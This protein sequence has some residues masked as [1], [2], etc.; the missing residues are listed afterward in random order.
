[1]SDPLWPEQVSEIRFVG[2]Y[3]FGALKQHIVDCTLWSDDARMQLAI[4]GTD[5]H[6]KRFAV[7]MR[8]SK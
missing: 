2:G 8:A 7:K 4:H 6:A 3:S 5:E 1:M